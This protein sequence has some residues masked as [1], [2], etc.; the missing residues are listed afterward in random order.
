[1]KLLFISGLNYLHR[2]NNRY[3]KTIRWAHKMHHRHLNKEDG[4]S[5][6]MLFVAKKYRDKIK[7]DK[8]LQKV[9]HVLPTK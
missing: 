8:T 1:M 6:G 7:K 2:S 9:M 4:E 5:F 3:I